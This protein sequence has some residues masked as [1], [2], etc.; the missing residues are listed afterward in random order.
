MY[1]IILKRFQKEKFII[2]VQPLI[3]LVILIQ[4]VVVFL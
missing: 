3:L 4:V 1:P 2:F